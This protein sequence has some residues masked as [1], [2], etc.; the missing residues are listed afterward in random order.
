MTDQRSDPARR[1]PADAT[2]AARRGAVVAA[3]PPRRGAPDAAGAPS[4]PDPSP[5]R[6]ARAAA[7]SRLPLARRRRRSCSSSRASRP[8]PRSRSPAT[9]RPD[10]L[11]LGPADSFG[12]A[13]VRLDLPGDQRQNLGRSCPRSPASPTAAHL[14]FK[15][16]EALDQ[17]VGARRPT[18]ERPSAGHPS[19][20]RRQLAVGVGA[21]P[22][23]RRRPAGTDARLRS[24]CCRDEG[25]AWPRTTSHERGAARADDVLRRRRSLS[26]IRGSGDVEPM[27]V[28]VRRERACSPRRRGVRQGRDRHRRRR[29][30]LHG[31]A[32]PGAA[33]ARHRRPARASA[34]STRRVVD[35]VA[36]A[37]PAQTPQPSDA[38]LL[39]ALPSWV[40]W[41]SAPVR[42]MTAHSLRGAATAPRGP[43]PSPNRVEHDARAGAA[44]DDR[45]PALE[46]PRPRRS[47]P[48][49]GST[50]ARARG[51]PRAWSRS[52][53]RSRRSAARRSS[54]AGSATAASRVTRDGTERRT[55]ASLITPEGRGAAR[56]AVRPAP[57]PRRPGRRP[58]RDHGHRGGRTAARRSPSIDLGEPRGC[59]E[60]VAARS[61]GDLRDRLRRQRDDVV[62]ARRSADV[63][64][65]PCSIPRPANRS[66]RPSATH[67]A[68]PRGRLQ[69]GPALRRRR[70][71]PRASS[72]PLPAEDQATTRRELEPYLE[73]FDCVIGDVTPGDDSTA[74]PSSSAC[75]R[76]TAHRL[77]RPPRRPC[78]G[79]TAE[80]TAPHGRSHSPDPRRRDQAADLPARRR[81]QPHRPRRARDRHDRALQPPHGPDR[82]RCRRGQGQGLAV[83]GRPARPTPSRACSSNAG[84]L[85]A[86]K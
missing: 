49:R 18:S 23:C 34:T 5:R 45:R 25:P 46:V 86:A 8:R 11:G 85:P 74:E 22:G 80:E 36:G 39:D 47:D 9:R 83:E 1:A 84:I 81:R 28:G 21:L 76:L 31:D 78:P 75:P 7:V 30:A 64:R 3:D 26:V 50:A 24:H 66:P 65:E 6:A 44:A 71:A 60:A 41:S 56:A 12:Y 35:G 2:P 27:L 59:G 82:A 29:R 42:A 73:P 43:R 54:S 48:R 10:V 37:Q 40:S 55:A 77:D 17:L 62:V 52:T 14:G 53:R 61:P 69:R 72:R 16:D 38:D 70:R 19:V 32:V 20:V 68:R 79:P 13:E 58:G 4:P 67:G 51:S 15:L 63:R 57:Q 33:M